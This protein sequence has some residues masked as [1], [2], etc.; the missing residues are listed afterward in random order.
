MDKFADGNLTVK[1]SENEED[2]IGRLFSGFNKVVS[3]IKYMILKILETVKTISNS[4]SEISSSTTEMAAGSEEQSTQTEEISAAIEE[5]TR[6]ILETTKNTTFA[7]TASQDAEKT[8]DEGGKVFKE[9]MSGMDKISEV[10]RNSSE[11]IIHLGNSSE[12]IGEII[13]VIDDIADQ[14]NL[15]ALNAAIEAARAGEQGR[16]FAIVADEVR[17]L[18]ERTTKA[19]NE[20]TVMIKQIQKET[21]EAVDSMKKGTLEVEHGK[22]L[23]NKVGNSLNQIIKNSQTVGQII[24]QV[25]AASNQQSATSEEISKNIES[26]NNVVQQNSF[27]IQQISQSA[28]SLNQMTSSLD[29][30]VSKFVVEEKLAGTY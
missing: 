10:V 29:A 28:E 7:A 27:G 13:G 2:E 5:M 17:K 6:T 24:L 8:A 23:V 15:L 9:T 11:K 4:T 18:A 12:Q 20:I 14:T 21:N 3:N 16:G 25:A 1:L 30:L 26:I 22:Q 19:T